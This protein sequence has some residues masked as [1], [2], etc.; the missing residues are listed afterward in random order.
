M[1]AGGYG[2]KSP[3]ATAAQGSGLPFLLSGQPTALNH[4]IRLLGSSEAL[5]S[6]CRHTAGTHPVHPSLNVS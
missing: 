3:Q 1:I 5:S 2:L 4:F 6:S